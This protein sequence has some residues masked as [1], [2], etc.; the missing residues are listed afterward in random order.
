[1][2][3][4][5]DADAASNGVTAAVTG[6]GAA[7]K[8][9]LTA[10][11]AGKAFVVKTD[12]TNAVAGK[13]TVNPD[14]TD[15]TTAGVTTAVAANEAQVSKIT[16]TGTVAAIDTFTVKIGNLATIT[17]AAVTG[18]TPDAAVAALKTAIE[19]NVTYDALYK[20]DI[21]VTGG[22]GKHFLT[23]TAK[24]P[25][26]AFN[27]PVV[28]NG[29]GA[30]ATIGEAEVTANATKVDVTAQI[31]T[32]TFDT[33][34]AIDAGDVFSIKLE[35]TVFTHVAIAGKL[36]A[37]DIAD[38]FD[39]LI[40]ASTE[41]KI[42]NII[43]A[44]SKDGVL[45][46]TGK[47]TGETFTLADVTAK[48]SD[49]GGANQDATIAHKAGTLQ[50]KTVDFNPGKI[51]IGDKF[52]VTIDGTEY[53]Y[54]ATD[55][56]TAAIDVVAGLMKAINDD[57][58]SK[59]T[60][61]TAGTP[62]G[63]LILTH[64]DVFAKFTLTTSA[65]N[66]DYI[67]GHDLVVNSAATLTQ[68]I[69][70][71]AKNGTNSVTLSGDEVITGTVAQILGAAGKKYISSDTNIK[72][73]A[74][75]MRGSEL[76]TILKMTTGKVTAENNVNVTV[77]TGKT[78][79]ITTEEIALG[80]FKIT[81]DDTTGSVNIKDDSTAGDANI[82]GTQGNDTL[83]GGKGSN[84]INGGAGADKID[85][86]KDALKDT[87]TIKETD[88]GAND[89]VAKM[90]E[91]ADIITNM[92]NGDTTTA[93]TDNIKLDAVTATNFDVATGT[94]LGSTVTIDFSTKGVYHVTPAKG[95]DLSAGGTINTANI[96]S[97]IAS[98]TGTNLTA[99]S[100]GYIAVTS[101]TGTTADLALFYVNDKNNDGVIDANEI[102]FAA[103]L[104][105]FGTTMTDGF[106]I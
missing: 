76:Q 95:G 78:L 32:V 42:K 35:G 40:D 89:T 33:T 102:Q 75:T 70:L 49:A 12:A 47:S 24:T 21:D 34:K 6:A 50:V 69:A 52:T 65:T 57:T 86:G 11:A 79:T 74:T 55:G 8:L 9:V 91:G 23:I 87:V 105:D 19:A 16:V 36:T 84:D 61:S 104:E 96:T 13:E 73:D 48:N 88:I 99:N 18:A 63:K 66:G 10:S 101:G 85:V 106:I 22:V 27:T 46:L 51:D 97:L 53:Q 83:T 28:A 38:A 56:K 98:I 60:A 77:E 92:K 4:L 41:V 1:M 5:I 14:P 15:A 25:G 29:V 30:G 2:K 20:I 54:V 82:I 17:T 58:S 90:I 37:S 100:D 68:L 7:G 31:S 80:K 45:T 64:D 94:L 44:T 39:A 26:T 67:T 71:D 93:T 3:A 59:V 72:I 103:V 81:A 43:T 62:D